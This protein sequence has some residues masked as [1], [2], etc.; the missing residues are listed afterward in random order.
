MLSISLLIY[1]ER[2]YIFFLQVLPQKNAR[3]I[4][5]KILLDQIIAAPF[6]AITFFIGAGLL[7]GK[8]FKETLIEFKKKFPAVYLVS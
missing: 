2:L 7:E 6:F 4:V 8:A 1:G 3:T 5:K